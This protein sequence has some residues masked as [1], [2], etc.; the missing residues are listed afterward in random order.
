MSST[1][2]EQKIE[3]IERRY[4][5]ENDI[6]PNGPDV[7]WVEISLVEIIKT[8]IKRIAELEARVAQFDPGS[9]SSGTPDAP[10]IFTR[11]L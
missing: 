2:V 3:E 5:P 4:N 1:N 9:G 10:D 8:L 7:N 6:N 11:G